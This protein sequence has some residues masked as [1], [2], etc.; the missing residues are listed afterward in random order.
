VYPNTVCWSASV[1]E[2]SFKH[3]FNIQTNMKSTA[4][5][6]LFGTFIFTGLRAQEVTKQDSY[7]YWTI[8]KDVQRVQYKHIR[9]KPSTIV[10]GN[11]QWM[12]SKGVHRP[13]KDISPVVVQTGGRPTWFISKGIARM[14]AEK[15]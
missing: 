11:G 12:I 13:T 7:P 15:K 1:K 2:G 9:L 8:S 6:L 14:Q 4:L 10:T 5:I 3:Y